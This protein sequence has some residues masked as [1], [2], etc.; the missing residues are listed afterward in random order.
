MTRLYDKFCCM[1]K[2]RKLCK[3]WKGSSHPEQISTP[4]D[5]RSYNLRHERMWNN[6]TVIRWQICLKGVIMTDHCSWQ[7]SYIQIRSWIQ[8]VL[9]EFAVNLYL[10]GHGHSI[11]EATDKEFAFLQKSTSMPSDIHRTNNLSRDFSVLFILYVNTEMI[12]YYSP[13]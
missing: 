13:S 2:N 3:A 6:Q 7:V 5:H 4:K 1:I 11:Q 12:F 8:E 10:H 9:L